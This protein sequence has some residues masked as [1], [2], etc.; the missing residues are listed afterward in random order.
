M[1]TRTL[2]AFALMGTLSSC[3][4]EQEP[5]PETPE[6]PEL[7]S[8]MGRWQLDV[9]TREWVPLACVVLNIDDV[10]NA[11]IEVIE[12]GS[13]VVVRL[14]GTPATSFVGSFREH[15]FSGR[16]IL[17]TTETGR[18]CGRETP[19]RLTLQLE[20]GDPDRL[21]GTWQTPDCDIC[22]DRR[23]EAVRAAG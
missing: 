14:L 23:F 22:P 21:R 4:T 2:L 5:R 15:M 13:D 3:T 17:A 19:V 16:Q 20:R 9:D 7:A 12:E 6:D 8:L 11:S 10:D 1:W 18:F